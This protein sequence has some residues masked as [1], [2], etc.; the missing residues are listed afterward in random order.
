MTS[1]KK[2]SGSAV[3]EMSKKDAEE[4]NVERIDEDRFLDLVGKK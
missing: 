4:N 3:D 1:A 2:E